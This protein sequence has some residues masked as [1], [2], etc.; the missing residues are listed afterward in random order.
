MLK[1]RSS[2]LVFA[3]AYFVFVVGV[4]LALGGAAYAADEPTAAEDQYNTPP[5]TVVVTPPTTTTQTTT[6]PTTTPSVP[7]ETPSVPQE[8]QP[9]VVETVPEEEE[10]PGTFLPPVAEGEREEVAVSRPADEESIVAQALP[11]TG[12][13][14]L[15]TAVIGGVL[16]ALGVALR[17]RERRN[18]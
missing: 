6:P 1:T 13:S 10:Q 18:G 11:N 2:T 9:D 8:T 5:T 12:L 17:R 4:F 14:L 15:A 16:V 7:Q 3:L